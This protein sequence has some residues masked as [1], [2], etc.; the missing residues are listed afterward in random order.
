[1]WE[2]L[3]VVWQI[4]E[5]RSKILL[6]LGLLGVYRLGFQI[7]LPIVDP[8]K[9]ATFQ[10]AGGMADILKQ[11]AVFSASQ[12][13]QVTI[14]GLGIMPYISASI[15]FQ[16]LG[17]VYPPLE[18]LQKEGEAGRKKIN[19][20]TRYATVFICIIQSWV[21]V[22]SIVPNLA[23][24]SF[25]V[26]PTAASRTL[27]FSWTIVAV[28]T[29]TAGTVF[30]M[31]IGEQIDEFGIGNGISLLI[32]AGILSAMPGAGMQLLE[33]SSLELTG[34][35]GELGIEQLLILAM[36]FVAVIVG[37]V[38][39]TLGQRQIPMQSAKHVR[40]RRVMGGTRQYL[41]LKV[42]QAGVMPII[43]AS[44]LLMLPAILFGAMSK[45]F[46]AN[47]FWGELFSKLTQM[48]NRT[49]F[50]YALC[51]IA[52]IYFFCFF[53]TAITFNP[54]DVADNLKNYGSFIPGYRPGKR[55]AD[56]L[57]K[58]MFRITYVG[59]GF[60]AL[61]AIVPSMISGSLNVSPLVA[62]FYGGTSLLIAVS[63]AFDLVQKID[64]HLV[65][66]NYKGLLES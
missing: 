27:F 33:Q 22:K 1:M 62:N 11:V 49:G 39:I 42:N 57:E 18:R 56:Y 4:P 9:V 53:W 52:L 41:P 31:W 13:D 25:V 14:F 65:M 2:K 30:L 35:G 50:V 24:D 60:L 12:L 21:Y 26:D 40:G 58:V 63:V 19:E 15:I 61:V 6:T 32:M 66:R 20:Y 34:G 16:L 17:S 47:G 55:T 3:R 28:L 8:S 64:S 44:S 29:M 51:Y 38:F 48:F 45:M 7:P 43:F 59:A 23:Y 54:K 5:L 10:K 46:D 37:V 36:M